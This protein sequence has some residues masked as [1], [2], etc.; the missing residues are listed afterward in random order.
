MDR[1]EAAA[2]RRTQQALVIE[3]IRASRRGGEGLPV[4]PFELDRSDG[5]EQGSGKIVVAADA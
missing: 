5:E 4:L 3:L 1:R 2:R